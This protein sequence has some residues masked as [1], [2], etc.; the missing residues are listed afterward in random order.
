M[1][2]KRE[3]AK[4]IREIKAEAAKGNNPAAR[5][6]AKSLVRLRGQQAK[7]LAAKGSLQGVKSQMTV[8]A[9]MW[10]MPGNEGPVLLV[11]SRRLHPGCAAQELMAAE[12]TAVEP[13][14]A[15]Y[16][17]VHVVLGCN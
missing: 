7:M 9:N 4:L 13:T 6:L 16:P 12:C 15:L 2:L 5:Q 1:G 8:R 17:C 14:V 3:E 11:L 10:S